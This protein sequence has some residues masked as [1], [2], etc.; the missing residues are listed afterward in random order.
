MT[1]FFERIGP[2]LTAA[3]WLVHEDPVERGDGPGWFTTTTMPNGI[4]V[5]FYFDGP[6]GYEGTA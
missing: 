1:G 6:L 2:A 5:E 4:I 3:G